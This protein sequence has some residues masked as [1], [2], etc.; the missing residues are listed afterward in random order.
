MIEVISGY[1]P[2]DGAEPCPVGQGR[3]GLD[4]QVRLQEAA[5]PGMAVSRENTTSNANRKNVWKY[6]NASARPEFYGVLTTKGSAP[7]LTLQPTTTNSDG[8]SVVYEGYAPVLLAR[9]YVVRPGQYLEPI[10]AGL[11]Q[12]CF[13]P[14]AGGKGV[15]IARDYVDNTGGDAPVWVGADI[16]PMQA[17]SGLFGAL[18]P[19]GNLTGVTAETAYD[20][21]IAIPANSLRLRDRFRVVGTVLSNNIAAGNN[22]VKGYVNGIASGALFTTPAVT[23]VANDVATFSVDA[24]LAAMSGSNN[25]SLSGFVAIGTPGSGTATARAVVGLS[26]LDPTVDNIITIANTPN[27]NADSSK[28]LFLSVEK[29]A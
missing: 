3:Y 22:V 8:V 28:L 4:D 20:I 23:F 15:A 7:L 16:L 25:L 19:S 13:R 17:G 29:L 26:T 10:P 5:L 18:G 12:A 14:A 24:Y 1:A 11:Q 2:F 27:S 6:G 21:T 9:G